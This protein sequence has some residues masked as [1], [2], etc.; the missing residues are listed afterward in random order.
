MVYKKKLMVPVMLVGLATAADAQDKQGK[1]FEKY[2]GKTI[3]EEKA[4]PEDLPKKLSDEPFLKV[5]S[6]LEGIGG[7]K[8]HGH[9]ERVKFVIPIEDWRI[10]I[11]AQHRDTTT[12]VKNEQRTI[13][14]RTFVS[15]GKYL[16]DEFYA[17]IA[18]TVEWLDYD[19]TAKGDATRLGGLLKLGY[20][21]KEKGI[22]ALLA[23]GTSKGDFGLDVQGL[24]FEDD[25]S[26][27]FA[28]AKWKVSLLEGALFD[29]DQDSFF[30]EDQ[31][32]RGGKSGLY[33]IGGIGWD[34]QEFDGLVDGRVLGGSLG[35]E[36]RFKDDWFIQGRFRIR[37]EKYNFAS[38]AKSNETY[39]GGELKVGLKISDYVRLEGFA[40]Y[41]QE[42]KAYGGVGLDISGLLRSK[43]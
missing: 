6:R 16:G 20:A 36:Y 13:A 39:W 34:K 14:N 31:E 5:Y 1:F 41:D 42:Y 29:D 35:L 27:T 22:K 43:K 12:E 3:Q 23:A 40:G 24:E 11:G 25:I 32:L 30:E 28:V 26:R 9:S 21:N 2:K 33:L 37:N 17:E 15:I 4:K 7:S 8:L 18:G 10:G 19:K 38:G